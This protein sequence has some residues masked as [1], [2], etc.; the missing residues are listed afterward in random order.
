MPS[1]PT[2]PNHLSISA[3]SR[4]F[5]LDRVT[6]KAWITKAGIEPVS[7]KATETLYNLEDVEKILSQDELEEAK[8]RKLQAEADLK[9][10]QLAEKRGEYAPVADFAQLTHEWIG[11][12]YQQSVKKVTSQKTL[13]A[14][15]RTKNETEARAVLKKEVDAVF[16]DFRANRHK[17]LEQLNAKTSNS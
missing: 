10:L 11:W 1:K 9:E 6:V 15:Q 16:A 7:S 4:K 12:L 5:D 3:L 13:K 14:I 17:I 2:D 8:L